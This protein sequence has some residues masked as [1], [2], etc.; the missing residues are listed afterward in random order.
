VTGHKTAYA[1]TDALKGRQ[2]CRLMQLRVASVAPS[3]AT[4]RERHKLERAGNAYTRSLS[5]L[6]E[7]PH[8]AGAGAMFERRA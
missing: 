1:I 7:I 6:F 8:V 5:A 3:S 2:Q 4:V